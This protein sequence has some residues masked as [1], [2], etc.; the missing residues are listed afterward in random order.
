MEFEALFGRDRRVSKREPAAGVAAEDAMS[1][2]QQVADRFDWTKSPA[3]QVEPRAYSSVTQY[4]P[5]ELSSIQAAGKSSP[6][7]TTAKTTATTVS[8][9]TRKS[10]I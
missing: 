10:V 9:F 1:I 5:G 2:W 7:S 8:S 6:T 3:G 4:S